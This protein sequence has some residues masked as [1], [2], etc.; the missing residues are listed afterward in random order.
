MANRLQCVHCQIML[1]LLSMPRIPGLSLKGFTGQWAL[2]V[3][4]TEVLV[5]MKFKLLCFKALR[6]SLVE[7]EVHGRHMHFD[8]SHIQ[9]LTSRPWVAENA[10]RRHS[11]AW[12][13][14]TQG[15]YFTWFVLVSTAETLYKIMLKK[16]AILHRTATNAHLLKVKHY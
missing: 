2:Q 14:G 3:Q 11:R 15:S 13:V 10:S 4:V 12:T 7:G 9:C 1:L 16:I 6:K 8:L 5:S